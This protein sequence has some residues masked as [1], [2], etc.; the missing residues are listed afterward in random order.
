MIIRLYFLSRRAPQIPIA[1]GIADVSQK[2][3]FL[4]SFSFY[5]PQIAQMFADLSQKYLSFHFIPLLF[6]SFYFILFISLLFFQ[7]YI[8]PGLKSNFL[9]IAET[10]FSFKT[11]SCS[12]L[13]LNSSENFRRWFFIRFHGFLVS[14]GENLNEIAGWGCNR[15]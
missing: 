11:T 12:T 15:W 3:F 10:A 1:I 13:T 8:C 2:Y 5:F 9:A 4:F 6:T 14:K 7:E